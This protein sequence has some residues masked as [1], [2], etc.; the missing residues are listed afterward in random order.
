MYIKIFLL[1]I[2]TLIL[3]FN[4]EKFTDLPNFKIGISQYIKFHEDNFDKN[5]LDKQ[6]LFDILS[7]GTKKKSQIMVKLLK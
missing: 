4:T 3:Y 2:L 6:Q 1:L 7:F 5:H